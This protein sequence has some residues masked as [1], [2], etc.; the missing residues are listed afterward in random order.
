MLSCNT[1]M[2]IS[3]SH[4][5]TLILEHAFGCLILILQKA[6]KMSQVPKRKWWAKAVFLYHTTVWLIDIFH[7]CITSMLQ[8][9]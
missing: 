4:F 8:A 7:G 3:N 6:E 5:S 1:G 2:L 9:P